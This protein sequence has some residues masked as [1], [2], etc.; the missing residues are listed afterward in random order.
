MPV[1]FMRQ[2]VD[3]IDRE[4]RPHLEGP[5]QENSF[6][7]C[8]GITFPDLTIYYGDRVR[9]FKESALKKSHDTGNFRDWC[10]KRWHELKSKPWAPERAPEYSRLHV[11]KENYHAVM[12][13]LYVATSGNNCKKV[14]QKVRTEMLAE[15]GLPD[16]Y[17]GPETIG[18][19]AFLL[20]ALQR[21]IK[22]RLVEKV[23]MEKR[24]Y[25]ECRKRRQLEVVPKKKK[26][27][28]HG[29]RT[30]AR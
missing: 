18:M 6:Q 27:K 1:N 5:E 13:S 12:T 8:R 14:D 10:A 2:C 29:K 20:R 15:F 30:T 17:R 19:R 28:A 3:T 26:R 16:D 25:E 24:Y 21:E 11:L 9:S 22:N 4:I 7:V 23:E